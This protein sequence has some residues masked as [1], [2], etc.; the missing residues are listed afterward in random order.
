MI[1]AIAPF[2]AMF[3]ILPLVMPSVS[4]VSLRSPAHW[5]IR[6]TH[7]SPD[8]GTGSSAYCPADNRPGTPS[9]LMTDC[10]AGRSTDSTSENRAPSR[11]VRACA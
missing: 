6:L 7:I 3:A 11:I 8:R 9:H 1:A 10:R 2:T 4:G 5:Q